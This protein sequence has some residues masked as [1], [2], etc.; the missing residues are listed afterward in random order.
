MIAAID[1]CGMMR[2]DIGPVGRSAR[3]CQTRAK[4]PI[5]TP[6]HSTPATISNIL[7]VNQP[8]QKTQFPRIGIS[9]R[10]F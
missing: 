2:N 8:G 10:K 5:V 3:S 1:V 6:C 4:V 9:H 7:C